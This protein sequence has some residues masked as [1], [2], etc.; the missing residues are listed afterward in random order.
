[1][2]LVR[3]TQVQLG[4]YAESS[5]GLVSWELLSWL[6]VLWEGEKFNS[7]VFGASDPSAGGHVF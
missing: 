6:L 7:D 1:M 2:C 4:M 3:L 5:H